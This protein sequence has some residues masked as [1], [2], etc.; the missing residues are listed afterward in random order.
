VDVGLSD[1]PL[2]LAAAHTGEEVVGYVRGPA[3]AAAVGLP[4]R[5]SCWCKLPLEIWY[6]FVG[7]ELMRFE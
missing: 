6:G 4:Q 1:M 3:G 5:T 7:K 2:D